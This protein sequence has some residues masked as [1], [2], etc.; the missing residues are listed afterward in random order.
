[1][2]SRIKLFF[3]IIFLYIELSLGEVI[4]HKYIMHNKKG[5]IRKL[6]GLSHIDHHIDVQYNMKLKKDYSKKGLYFSLLD[7][8]YISLLIFISWYP[9]ILL[10]GY[11]ILLKYIIIL[12]LLVGLI[13]NFSWNFLHYSFHQVK[14]L[15]KY[16][17]NPIFN[18][19]FINHALHHL[20]KGEKKGNYNMLFPGGDHILNTYNSCNDNMELCNKIK[21]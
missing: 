6:Y 14:E 4:V 16:R 1:M 2:T 3:L 8:L 9:T 5:I 19:L 17:K 20:I 21:L 10:F 11:N 7:S 12:S 13:Y 18:W 15:K